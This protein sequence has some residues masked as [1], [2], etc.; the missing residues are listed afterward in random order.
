MPD[1]F[2]NKEIASTK[3][4]TTTELQEV[5]TKSQEVQTES[6]EVQTESQGPESQSEATKPMPTEPEQP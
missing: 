6:Q 5:Q 3:P 4:T 2:F 1:T